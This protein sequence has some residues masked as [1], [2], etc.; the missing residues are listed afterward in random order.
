[1]LKTTLIIKHTVRIIQYV[2]GYHFK[3]HV[4]ANIY[5]VATNFKSSKF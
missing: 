4:N 3:N 1:M 5:T 2:A